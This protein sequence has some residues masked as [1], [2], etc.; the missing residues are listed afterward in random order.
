MSHPTTIQARRVYDPLLRLL[1]WAIALSILALIATS[2]LAEL[3]EHGPYEDT[4]WNLHIVSGY[5]LAAGLLTRLLWGL[6]GPASARWRDLWHPAVWKDSLRNL[7]LPSAHRS[8]HDPI[9]SLGY[10]FAYGVMALMVVTGLGL[11][12]SE[13]QAGPLAAWL[14]NAGWLEDVLGD[15]HE[16]GFV[17]LLGFIGLHMAA[18]VFHQ[19]RGE[20]VAQS[21]F[22]GE[23]YLDA[24]NEVQHD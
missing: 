9:A 22:T 13:F 15:P 6:V 20:R 3:F 2:Q 21:M 4:L 17:L 8:G 10:L 14:G 11:A 1:H 12:A 16:A 5:V 24:E 23:Q 19:W 7:R 18:L